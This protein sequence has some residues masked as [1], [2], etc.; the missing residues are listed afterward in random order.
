[1]AGIVVAYQ[2]MHLATLILLVLNKVLLRKKAVMIGPSGAMSLTGRMTGPGCCAKL[3]LENE[4]AAGHPCVV[5]ASA[6]ENEPL[7][8]RPA[9]SSFSLFSFLSSSSSST[10]AATSSC[11]WSGLDPCALFTV[12]ALSPGKLNWNDNTT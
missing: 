3:A 8:G 12:Q 1:M 6:L 10:A 11:T 9:A 2:H 7:K 5:P 4:D